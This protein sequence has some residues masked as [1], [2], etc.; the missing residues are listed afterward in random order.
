MLEKSKEGKYSAKLILGILVRTYRVAYTIDG[1]SLSL[2][3]SCH[4]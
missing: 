3:L 4:Y 2:F 1:L